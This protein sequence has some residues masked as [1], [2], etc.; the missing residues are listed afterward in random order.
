MKKFVIMGISLVLVM[1]GVLCAQEG[2]GSGRVTGLVKDSQGNPLEGVKITMESLQF[3]FTLEAVSATNGRWTIYGFGIGDYQFTAEKDGYVRAISRTTLSGINRNPEQLIVLKSLEEI[4]GNTGTGKDS[5]VNFKNANDL[6]D[7]GNYTDAL[8]MFQAF[9]EKNPKYYK[10]NINI[11]NCHFKLKQYDEA[12]AAYQKV[13]EGMAAE[14]VTMEGDATAAQVYAGIGE[15][16][17]VRND[18]DKAKE[19]FTKAIEIDPSDRALPYNVAEILFNA[20]NASEAVT[21]YRQAIAI[22]PDWAKAHRQLGYALLNQGDMPGAITAFKT[23]LEKADKED[24]QVPV[25]RDLVSSLE[26]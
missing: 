7:A 6:Y 12:V 20:G 18:F 14:G 22:S 13:L 1:T 16:H 17:M 26:Q 8:A 21:Y 19:F 10:V 3:K 15:A 23:Y 24:P 5:K 25:I 11:G 2:R 4:K 9:L